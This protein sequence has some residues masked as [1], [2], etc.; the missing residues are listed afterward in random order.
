MCIP[1][2]DFLPPPPS[3]YRA[4]LRVGLAL[5]LLIRLGGPCPIAPL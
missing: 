1:V 4:F 2:K 3:D 5:G